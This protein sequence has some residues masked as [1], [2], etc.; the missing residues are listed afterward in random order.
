VIVGGRSIRAYSDAEP[1]VEAP[2]KKRP[3]KTL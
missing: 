1:A 3:A 2:A